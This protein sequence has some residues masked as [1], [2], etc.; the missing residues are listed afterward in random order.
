M[1]IKKMILELATIDIKQGTNADFEQNLEKAQ[2][3]IS[4]SKGYLGHEFQKCIE[5]D[6]RYILL[7]KWA[8]LK[9]H[10]EGFRNS[11]LFKEWR[12]LIGPFFENPP[13][14]EHFDLKFKMAKP[15][16]KI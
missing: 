15:K 3:V 6:N 13:V 7:I 9:A 16:K 1:K 4:Q 8:N 14:V 5:R 10:T 2:Y 12:A 11:E